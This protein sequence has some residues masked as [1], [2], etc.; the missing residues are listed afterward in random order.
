MRLALVEASDG[1]IGSPME[2]FLLF[3]CYRFD[4]E[5]GSYAMSA[6]KIMRLAGAMTF[7]LIVLGIFILRRSGPRKGPRIGREKIELGGA[8]S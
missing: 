8:Q 5:A 2:K 3:T 4:P 1:A 6:M 7:V